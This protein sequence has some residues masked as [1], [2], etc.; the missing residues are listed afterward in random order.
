LG[1]TGLI[2]HLFSL[3]ESDG[4]KC[5]F[6]D[7]QGTSSFNDLVSKLA[8]SIANSFPQKSYEKVWEALKKM[9][10]IISFDQ[11]SGLPEVSFNFHSEEDSFHTFGSLMNLLQDQGSE[12]LLAFDEFQQIIR[13]GDNDVEGKL[14]NE[15]QQFSGLNY[16][17]SGSQTHLL[18][19]MFQDGSRPF[20]GNVQ[21]LHLEK[22]EREV[23]REF[24]VQKFAENRKQIQSEDVHDILEWT[25]IHTYYTQYFCNQLFL[26]TGNEVTNENI[27]Q[28]KWK[29]LDMR[30]QDHFQLKDILSSGHWK[31][32]VATAGEEKLR[33]PTSRIISD[34]YNL[35]TPAVS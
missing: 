17:F 16:L 35:G 31:L 33:K 21:K 2:K 26:E 23:Y 6:V 25:S 4:I 14:R 13:Y 11:F 10:P 32:L 18:A 5:I 30:R 7:L 28:L 15:M 34:K 24:I 1:K 20:F 29:I 3:L 27:N 12:I 8:G 9:K 19:R 22:I